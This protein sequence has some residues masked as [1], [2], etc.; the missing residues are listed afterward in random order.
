MSEKK[1]M[2]KGGR[3][4][5]AQF[6]QTSLKQAVEFAKKLVAKTHNEPQPENIILK[7]VFN[8]AGPTGKVR[9]SALKQYD[10]MQGETSAYNATELAR[11]INSAPPEE[12]G[13]LVRKAFLHPKVFKALFDTFQ[14]D[15]VSRAKIRQQ[16]LQLNVHPDSGDKCVDLFVESGVYAG[17]ASEKDGEVQISGS[18]S[19]SK[20]DEDGV[21]GAEES[22]KPGA[23]KE[24]SGQD[25]K[26]DKNNEIIVRKS[27]K[28]AGGQMNIS[29]TLD[30]TMDPEKLEKYL[31][32]L[33]DYGAIG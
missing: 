25:V 1:K 9:A 27:P 12:L 22:D 2:P 29:I 16:A 21:T 3:K 18:A 30:S 17:L 8:S 13:P 19:L 28:T 32:L 31:K 11:S 24:S 4:G 10:L 20:T 15:T 5:G 14:N 6:P 23:Q 26:G 7:G 33:R